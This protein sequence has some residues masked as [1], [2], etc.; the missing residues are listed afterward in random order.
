MTGVKHGK[1]SPQSWHY[2]PPD[3]RVPRR[4]ISTGEGGWATL[5]AGP[6]WRHRRASR[7]SR[8]LGAPWVGPPPRPRPHPRPGLYGWSLT[9]TPKNSLG[10]VGARSGT[11]GRSGSVG[12]WGRSGS[13]G[14]WGRCR[15]AGS[16]GRFRGAGTGACSGLESAAFGRLATGT[17]G[18]WVSHQRR[19]WVP[20]RRRA[21]GSRGRRR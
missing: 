6:G 5:E 21:W 9:T 2:P 20:H 1:N 10:R 8:G 19:R 14:T 12:T 4:N 3:R 16:G 18:A 13:A 15:G 17:A 7:R 11:R